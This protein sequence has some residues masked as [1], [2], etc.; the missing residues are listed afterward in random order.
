MPPCSAPANRCAKVW[1]CSAARVASFADVRVS[2]R[3]LIWNTDLVETLEL[4]NLLLPGAGHDHRPR[5]NREESRGAH[6]RE[7]FP[8]RDDENW[9]KHTLVW[10]ASDGAGQARLPARCTCR[11]SRDDVEA[12]PAQGAG[13]LSACSAR[14]TMAEFRL[15]ANSR[16]QPG[17]DHKAPAGARRA[18]AGSTSTA[19]TRDGGENPRVDTYEV[20]LDKCGPMVLDA[21]IK[22]KNE[23]D[24]TLTFRRSCREGICGSCAM[25]IDGGNTLACTQAIDDIRGDVKIYPLPHMPVIKDLVPDLTNFYAQY[26][27]IKP[28]LQ[29]RTPPPPDRERLQSKEEQEHIN[30]PVGLHPLRLLLDE[31]PE[32]L[33]EQRPLSGPGG[34]AGR[35]PLAGGQSRRGD[36][37]AARRTRGSVPAVSLPHDHELHEHLPE[38]SESGQGHRRNEEDDRRAPPL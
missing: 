10:V 11:R 3:S 37:R 33:V 13:L 1:R 9:M 7:D 5:R 26:A 29:T 2:D 24:A 6:A 32:L 12:D 23:I 14:S 22:I 19:T 30:E 27:S 15:P 8:E 38:G 36:G 18:C 20:D 28:W 16:I 17:R 25:N 4:E 34:P 31:L 35:L 21:L